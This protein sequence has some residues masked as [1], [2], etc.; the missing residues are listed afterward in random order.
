[1]ELILIQIGIYTVKYYHFLCLLKNS[2][3]HYAHAFIFLEQ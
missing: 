1:M 3:V 2:S